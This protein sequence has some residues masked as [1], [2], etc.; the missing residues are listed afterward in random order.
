MA[1]HPAGGALAFGQDGVFLHKQVCHVAEG[2]FRASGGHLR[3]RACFGLA[4]EGY[5]PILSVA[6]SAI[7]VGQFGA[8]AVVLAVQEGCRLP[9]RAAVAAEDIGSAAENGMVVLCGN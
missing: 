4:L 8:V 1:L 9:K 2:Q 3:E 6:D 7:E 5:V